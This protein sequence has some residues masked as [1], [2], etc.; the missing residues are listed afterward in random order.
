MS[1]HNKRK[2]LVTGDGVK[3]GDSIFFH[4]DHILAIHSVHRQDLVSTMTLDDLKELA[5]WLRLQPPTDDH[6]NEG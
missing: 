5:S 3:R 4:C 6:L 1:H 2:V